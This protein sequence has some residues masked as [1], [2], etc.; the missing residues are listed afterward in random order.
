MCVIFSDIFKLTNDHVVLFYYFSLHRTSSSLREHDN[1][2]TS[3]VHSVDGPVRPHEPATGKALPPV[4][5]TKNSKNIDISELV[6]NPPEDAQI[7]SKSLSKHL[8]HEISYTK[9]L[10]MAR[11]LHSSQRS[12]PAL[13]ASLGS[14]R[15]YEQ[16]SNHGCSNKLNSSHGQHK[17]LANVRQLSVDSHESACTGGGRRDHGESE[18]E[19]RLGSV[20]QANGVSYTSYTGSSK[21]VGAFN[22]ER[23]T[24]VER[25]RSSL[26]VSLN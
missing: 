9:G 17:P 21:G 23:M 8:Q 24:S 4:N 12:N 26:L 22:K 5:K 6:R 1:P 11:G 19:A 3:Y 2:P 10:K 7:R 13:N 15:S 14:N 18:I 16:S 25:L 20:G